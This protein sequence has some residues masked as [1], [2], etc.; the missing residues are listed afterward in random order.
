MGLARTDGRRGLAWTAAVAAGLAWTAGLD[1]FFLF[2]IIFLSGVRKCTRQPL[3]CVPDKRHTANDL[4]PTVV[5]RVRFAVCYTRQS[6]FREFFGLCRVLLAHG[7]LD[8]SGSEEPGQNF[9]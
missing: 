2:A 5:Y 7:K 9:K 8:D 1:F 4:F 6:F 3:C